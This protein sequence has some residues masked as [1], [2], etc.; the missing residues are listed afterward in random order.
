MDKIELSIVSLYNGV[1]M[2]E[3]NDGRIT[4]FFIP[5]NK[6]KNK[7]WKELIDKNKS[8]L[9]H[10]H[11]TK[12]ARKLKFIEKEIINKIISIQGLIYMF[13]D[14]YYV[15]IGIKDILKNI[16]FRDI[17]RLDNLI[18]QKKKF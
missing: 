18:H 2:K 16:T 10:I 4:Y 12:Y 13:S 1:D 9:I 11:G 8:A 7:Y 5:N 15:N 17:I 6:E 3:Y 14:V